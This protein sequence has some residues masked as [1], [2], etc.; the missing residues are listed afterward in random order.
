M[1][2]VGGP[3]LGPIVGGAMVQGYLGWRWTE[4]ITGIMQMFFLTLG[5]IYLDERQAS[6]P[7]C[8]YEVCSDRLIVTRRCSWYTKLADFVTRLV[9]GRYMPLTRNGMS[10][11]KSWRT[12]TLSGPSNFS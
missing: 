11:L 1:A 4:Y 7:S 3:V 8:D 9:T 12:N 5:V 6:P 10:A 2:L